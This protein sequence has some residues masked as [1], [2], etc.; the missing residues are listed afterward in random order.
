MNENLLSVPK[1]A[2]RVLIEEARIL[3]CPLLGIDDFVRFCRERDLAV[4]RERL[5]RFERLGLF[6]PVFRVRAPDEAPHFVIPLIAGNNWF[7]RGWAWDTISE[8]TSYA[9][10]DDNDR[11]QQAYYSIF[12]IRDLE[13]SLSAL[14][15]ELHL[16]IYLHNTT[17]PPIDA[18]LKHATEVTASLR[19]TQFPTAVA[20]LCQYISNHY[21]PRTQGDR[22]VLRS[23]GHSF[24]DAWISVRAIDRDWEAERRS[25]N[26][27]D[28]ASL[29]ELT[30]EKLKHAYQSLASAQAWADPLEEWYELVQFVS[31]DQRKRLKGPALRAETLRE[32]AHM[33]RWL[34]KDMY[35]TL[36]PSP[37]E[38]YRTV[39]T[40]VPELSVRDDVRRYL[41][42]VA[43]KFGVNPQ[44]KVALIVEGQSEETLITRL[45]DRG[46]GFH[47]GTACIEIV[48]IRGV[49]NAT[50]E[51]KRDRFRAILRLVDYLHHRQTLCFLILDNENWAMRLKEE[52]RTASSI[53]GMRERVIPSDRIHVWEVSLEF[54]NAS[55][56]ELADA[57]SRVAGDQ[58]TFTCE[59][60]AA[61]RNEKSPGKA[62]ESLYL[63]QTGN[64]LPKPRLAEEIATTLLAANPEETTKHPII[65]L[66][67]HIA[68]VAM[69][70]PLPT[71]EAIWRENQQSSVFQ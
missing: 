31:L 40:H 32:G 2:G 61:C 9:I 8:A 56:T 45:F 7:E 37:N 24:D 30:P 1:N 70:N 41:E 33:L 59:M 34:Y 27:A 43:N 60:V 26:P 18:F 63:H 14:S 39:I 4:S 42:F 44:P 22:R 52:A 21:Y 11:S 38:V 6:F 35:Q 62:L 23:G 46:F 66:L 36:L 57:L 13:F 20:L 53:H 49:G 17:H 50:G 47:P 5:L 3:S 67:H 71:M 25:W 64:S 19:S 65:G 51:K 69:Q 68:S 12:Q 48:N 15:L 58:S 55:D 29:F 28:V 16:D 10:P 54:D